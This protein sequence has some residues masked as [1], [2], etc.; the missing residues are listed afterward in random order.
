LSFSYDSVP[1]EIAQDPNKPYV[2]AP[3]TP[4]VTTDVNDDDMPF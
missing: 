3:Y 4:S 2:V 1:E